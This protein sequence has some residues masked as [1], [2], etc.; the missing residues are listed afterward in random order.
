MTANGQPG[1]SFDA[2]VIGSGVCG[3]ITAYELRRRGVERVLIL[4]AGESGPD[5]LELVGAFARAT[6]KTPGSPYRGREG[7]RKAPGPE[8]RSDYYDQ[9]TT[10]DTFRSTYLRR[11]GGSTWHFLGNVPRLLPNDLRLRSAYGVGVD[12]PLSYDDLEPDYCTAEELLG[13]AGDHAQWDQLFGARRSRE[14]PMPP[15]WESYSDRRVTPA[16]EDLVIDGVQ[17]R[18]MRTPQARNSRPYDD[19]PPCAGNSTCVPICPIQAKYDG[20]VHVAKAIKHGAELRERAV[21]TRLSVD[22]NSG[23]VTSVHYRSWDGSDYAVS[24]RIVV[25]AAHAIE[26]AKLLLLSRDGGL[27]NSSDQVGRNLMDHPQGAGGC[28]AAEPL[29]PFRGPPTTSGIDVFRDGEFR[30][31]HAAFRMSLGNDGWGSRIESPVQ[32]VNRLI[33]DGLFGAGL[34]DAVRDRLTHQFRISYS[35]EML[36]DPDNRVTVSAKTDELG[37]PQPA[38]RFRVSAYNHAAFAQARRVIHR[39]LAAVGAD[40][41]IKFSPESDTDYTGAGHILG[42]CRMA[43]RAENGVVD[44]DGCSFD[45]GNLFIVGSSVFPTSG[46]ANP[47]LTAVALTLRTARR[48]A[49]DLEGGA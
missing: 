40:T 47:T 10:G 30:R 26:S 21:V 17:L 11:V 25:L 43:E 23:R 37:I 3:A 24:G 28:L 5:R 4:E 32:T 20:T 27:A 9:P 7:D 13:V 45:H 29:Y 46:T 44:R 49:D 36:P 2:V 12:W 15:I 42:T 18:V 8:T 35:T 48:V 39:I 33:D 38:L 19:R 31:D 34:R 6:R 22:P 41:T 16:I 1:E 14:F